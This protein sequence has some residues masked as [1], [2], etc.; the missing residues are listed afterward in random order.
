MIFDHACHMEIFD[1][2]RAVGLDDACGD[3]VEKRL[4]DVTDTSVE[5][6]QPST[7]PSPTGAAALTA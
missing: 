5:P 7:G 1:H 4:T 3:G 6:G 2:D